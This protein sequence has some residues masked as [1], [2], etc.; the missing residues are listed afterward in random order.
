MTSHQ[1]K[2]IGM[3]AAIIFASAVVSGSL[4]YFGMNTAA[5]SGSLGDAALDKRI[6]A[7]IERYV[8]KKQAEMEN[9]QAEAAAAEAEQTKVM[10]KNLPAVSP[11]SD[12]I[13][14]NVNAKI[15]LVEYSDF[16]CPFCKRF[17]GTAKQIVDKYAGDVNWIYRHYPLPSHDPAATLQ[18][19]ASECVAEQGGN[20]KF[21]EFTD[22]LFN[23]GPSD[24]TALAAAVKKM[25]LDEARFT[26]CLESE[27]YL[28]KIQKELTEGSN[29]GV[30]GTP[31]N[32]IV[33]NSG[34]AE[35]VLIPGAQGLPVFQKVIDPLLTQ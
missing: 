15:S 7:G 19:L 5:G 8:Q 34:A 24:K 1:Q 31:G 21:W 4:V 17:H 14:G 30:D 29:A 13:Y 25:G 9:A 32:F 2:D 27:K 20:A 26:Q 22:I 3:V 10:A 28:S 18:A 23:E 16:Q 11:A 12:H 33:L 6:D 35:S